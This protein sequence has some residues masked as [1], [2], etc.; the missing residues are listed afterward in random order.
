M[1]FYIREATKDDNPILMELFSEV[2]KLHVKNRPDFHLDVKV[3]Y[4]QVY[5]TN[6]YEDPKFKVFVAAN[7]EDDSVLGYILLRFID[8]KPQIIVQNPRKTVYI[9]EL[10]INEEHRKKNIGRQLFER[11]IEFGKEVGADSIELGVWEFNTD[12]ISFYEKIG[13][14]TQLRKMEMRL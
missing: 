8:S 9:H 11:T 5:G 12:A 1:E 4:E 10:C 3:T 14:K 13:M 2:Q 7:K 6:I